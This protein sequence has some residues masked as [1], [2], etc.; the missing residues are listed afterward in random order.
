MTILG[1]GDFIEETKEFLSVLRS[2]PMV[3]EE[4]D[5]NDWFTRSLRPL[6]ADTC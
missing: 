3:S 5:P 4:D 1:E 2:V 6:E